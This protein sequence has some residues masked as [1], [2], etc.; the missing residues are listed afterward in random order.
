MRRIEKLAHRQRRGALLADHAEPLNVL[1][2][3]RVFEEE[4]TEALDLL[5]KADS[6]DGRYALVD[7]VQ[8][9]QFVA[10]FLAH[11]L[12]HFD[13]SMQV[14]FGFEN[15]LG[16]ELFHLHVAAGTAVGRHAGHADLHA[17]G[18]E[19]FGEEPMNG[20]E[21]LREVGASGVGIAVDGLAAFAAQQL[22]N[23]Q[24]ALASLD[25]PQGLVD[26]ADGVVEYGAVAPVGGIV[27]C[28]PEIVDA[29]GG[30]A[31]EKR[32][33]V[34][35]DGRD[36]QIGALGK[37]A[38]AVAIEPVLVGEDFDD[39]QPQAIGRGRD[40]LDVLDLRAGQRAGGFGDLFVC[41]QLPR[42]QGAGGHEA[43]QR[44]SIH[45]DSS[46][47]PQTGQSAREAALTEAIARARSAYCRS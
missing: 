3:E 38:A 36:D 34:L 9:F 24:A 40:D 28:L 23:R 31:D 7:I 5:G 42:R 4:E 27:H 22:V 12:K 37:R 6:L 45:E 29:V 15:R 26:T 18:A 10:E 35:F 43:E 11:G 2:R 19:A 32:L 13:G 33:E 8:D 21:Q 14:R 20:V 16:V 46:N 1:G 17:N 30:P 47:H 41:R 39:D 44:P 25:I